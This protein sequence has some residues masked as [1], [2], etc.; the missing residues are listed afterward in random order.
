MGNYKSVAAQLENSGQLQN[1]TV[2]AAISIT[3]NCVI[4]ISAD[5]REVSFIACSITL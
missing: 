1:N 3:T 2:N 5:K 4:K